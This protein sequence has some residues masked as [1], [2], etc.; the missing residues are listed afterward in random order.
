MLP[1]FVAGRAES[2]I[3][4]EIE[5]TKL[6]VPEPKGSSRSDPK[7]MQEAFD[8]FQLRLQEWYVIALVLAD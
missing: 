1:Y 2:A 4:S 3:L 5:S 6:I 7:V 8:L